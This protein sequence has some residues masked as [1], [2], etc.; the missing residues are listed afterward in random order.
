MKGCVGEFKEVSK[1]G[2]DALAKDGPD[3][4]EGGA[5][6]KYGGFCTGDLG[7]D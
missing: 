3:G 1:F 7:A 6:A 5:F 4:G 2:V